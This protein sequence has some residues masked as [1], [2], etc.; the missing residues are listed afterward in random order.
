VTIYLGAAAALLVAAWLAFAVLGRRDFQRRRRPSAFTLVFQAAI[1]F[2]WGGFPM[3]Y[4]IVDWPAVGHGPLLAGIGWF[5]LILGLAL[6]AVAM[7]RL[8]LRRS[9]GLPGEEVELN[10]LYHLCRNPQIVGCGLY[11]LGFAILW[12]S[13]YAAGWLLL[14]A[15]IAHLMVRTEEEN[16]SQ[17][18]SDAYVEYCRQVPRYIPRLSRKQPGPTR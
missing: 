13:W 7:A 16:L 6:M 14:Y 15:A 10:G 1:F 17:R 12:P 18:Y 11:G 8:G 4:G 9:F 2:C 3:I 5:I